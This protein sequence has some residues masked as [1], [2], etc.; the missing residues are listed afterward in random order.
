MMDK[1]DAERLGIDPY[2]RLPF[3]CQAL[4]LS[5]SSIYRLIKQGEFPKQTY[6][7]ERTTAWRLSE[8]RAWMEMQGAVVNTRGGRAS[9]IF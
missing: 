5:R 6:L 7:S 8:L 1:A 9:E 4:G 2:V 3:V